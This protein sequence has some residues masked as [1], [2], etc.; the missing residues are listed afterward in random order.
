[1]V[2]ADC[3]GNG[4]LVRQQSKSLYG[5]EWYGMVQQKNFCDFS[6]VKISVICL[7]NLLY[8]NLCTFLIFL[9]S[10]VEDNETVMVVIAGNNCME[11][12]L[13]GCQFNYIF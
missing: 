4:F 5:H 8:G 3:T 12:L 1:M 2:E 11:L 13:Y 9:L 7:L 6:V 10:I